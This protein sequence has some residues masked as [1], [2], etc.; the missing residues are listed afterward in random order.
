VED[1]TGGGLASR[2]S[3]IIGEQSRMNTNGSPKGGGYRHN[4]KKDR[5][6]E[7][8]HAPSREVVREC[9]V[10]PSAKGERGKT[11]G[12]KVAARGGILGTAHL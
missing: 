7:K 4:K 5:E 9:A 1:N 6:K 11:E 2:G 10:S 8:C 3:R 12:R